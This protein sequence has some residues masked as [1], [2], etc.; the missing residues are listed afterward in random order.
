[1]LSVKKNA[2][3]LVHQ[4]FL[5]ACSSS[6]KLNEIKDLFERH[7]IDV[8]LSGN[9]DKSALFHAINA[10]SLSIVEFLV[11][12]GSD[13]TKKSFVFIRSDSSA[14]NFESCH[15]PPLVTAA[16]IGSTEILRCLLIHENIGCN[17][18]NERSEVPSH[19][20]I[21]SSDEKKMYGSSALHFACEAADV[22]MVKL[23]MSY[24]ADV[25]IRDEL[26]VEI[27]LHLIV[28]CKTSICNVQ[29]EILEILCKSGAN[30]NLINK[31]GCSPLYLASLY[32]C[33]SKVKILLS[34]GAN[35]N[36]CSERESGTSILHLSSFKD[37]LL[38]ASLLINNGIQMNNLNGN[39]LTSLQLNINTHCRSDIAFLLIYHGSQ[40]DGFNKNDKSLMASCINNLRLD[41]ENLSAFMIEAG[42]NLNQDLWLVPQELRQIYRD[43]DKNNMATDSSADDV[44]DVNVPEGRVKRL[45]DWLRL[46]QMNPRRLSECCRRIIR[47]R[48][49]LCVE[50]RS[51]VGRIRCLP[52]PRT[53]LRF[54]LLKDAINYF[55][56]EIVLNFES[57]DL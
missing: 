45:C 18:A 54:I 13:V 55:G 49:S 27:P 25:N 42:Y 50:G 8:N 35:V 52:L 1:M 9:D 20:V 21:R 30:V 29:C 28:K 32:E 33:T 40:M 37:Q 34:F 36:D 22:E 24:G 46:K 11:R 7:V 57:N 12:N 10:R 15:E 5:K 26:K 43:L 41:C 16:R 44:P 31:K 3:S 23:L 53:L 14:V 48:L 17:N 39:G 56:E 6:S 47:C 51:I 4:K 2:T 19:S 38:L